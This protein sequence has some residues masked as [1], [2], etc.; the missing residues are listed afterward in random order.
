[1]QGI[2]E[3]IDRRS[4]HSLAL[5]V[6]IRIKT[7]VPALVVLIISGTHT[8]NLTA[9]PSATEDDS[10]KIELTE[11]YDRLLI[12]ARQLQ[13]MGNYKD[14]L[15]NLE[16]AHEL[17]SELKS[18]FGIVS[19][20]VQESD[21]YLNC[22][23]IDQAK[24]L[25]QQ[26]LEMAAGLENQPR[27]RASVL[28]NWGIILTLDRKYEDAIKAFDQGLDLA[29]SALEPALAVRILVNQAKTAILNDNLSMAEEAL[30]EGVALVEKLQDSQRKAVL[31]SA[32][33]SQLQELLKEDDPDLSKPLLKTNARNLRESVR[34]F[35]EVSGDTRL[36]SN[37][38]GNIGHLYE[39]EGEYDKAFAATRSAL[40]F[41]QQGPHPEMTYRW[42]WQLGRLFSANGQRDKALKAYQRSINSLIPIQTRL[43]LGY[44]NSPD[45]FQKNIKPVY[46][47]LAAL[48]LEAAEKTDD[49]D[50]QQLQL[51]KARLTVEQMKAA[52]V[53][54]FFHDE[55]VVALRNK[56]TV[57]DSIGKNSAII[58]PMPFKDKLAVI[59]TL[60]SGIVQI[61]SPVD[62]EELTKT[63]KRFREHL[64]E[65]S[66]Q[67]FADEGK[68]LYHW[69]IAALEEKLQKEAIDT[70]VIIPDD[71]LSLIPFAALYDGEQFLL[72][73]YAIV[74]TPGLQLTDP[75]PAP[76][77]NFE[78]LLVGLSE[79]VQGFPQLPNIP[80]ELNTI[81]TIL[82]GKSKQLL[83]KA[84]EKQ[85]LT[86]TIKQTTY[87]IIHMATHGEFSADPSQT[88]L[89][90]YDSKLLLNEFGKLLK[91]GQFSNEPVELLTLSACNT[92]VGDIRAAFGLAGI[93]LE[94]GARSAVATL[95]SVDDESTMLLMTDF[96]RQFQSRPD[97]NKAQILQAAQLN[98]L[99]QSQYRHP[100][101]WSPFL[102][103]GNW[104]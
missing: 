13:N 91:L 57:L 23:Q 37:A 100:F 6:F 31:S 73:K 96:Y 33:A 61:A 17:A 103:I 12:E 49:A 22:G 98:L 71:A 24:K 4:L 7:I 43:M 14:A 32:L 55:C 60:P 2:N 35:A 36:Q 102:F 38:H 48:Y 104:L 16:K 34:V 88:F 45:Y 3:M 59:V 87:R 11:R 72:E 39:L 52:E 30:Y 64:Q 8:N 84:Y 101:Y 76:R 82:Q 66:H 10:Q 94:S 89:L 29:K 1:M 92:A 97:L 80:E 67:R 79:S 18:S 65:R 85:A 41:A 26:A 56:A 62:R 44:R 74:T 27:L 15:I 77:E 93:A 47:G 5:I 21:I 68:K 58:Y 40:F 19:V 46:Y 63:V 69:L 53:E 9:T 70:L 78:T 95:W 20:L 90:T 54:D 42:Q 25:G 99:N 28:N 75:R 81:N 86:D 83:D 50:K 51:Q